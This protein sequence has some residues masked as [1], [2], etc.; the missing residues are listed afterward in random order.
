MLID[1][2]KARATMDIN[3]ELSQDSPT[4]IPEQE[5]QQE[6]S[7]ATA[8]SRDSDE[9]QRQTMDIRID[10]SKG[11]DSPGSPLNLPTDVVGDSL[12]TASEMTIIKAEDTVNDALISNRMPCHKVE[13]F[14]HKIKQEEESCGFSPSTT[15]SL[16]D[17]HVSSVGGCESGLLPVSQHVGEMVLYTKHTDDAVV[18]EEEEYPGY[19]LTRKRKFPDDES[20]KPFNDEFWQ[21]YTH[22][23][24]LQNQASACSTT[25]YE[26]TSQPPFKFQIIG[27][28][29]Q[30]SYTSGFPMPEAISRV[31]SI[32]NLS[33]I[34]NQNQS[35][36]RGNDPENESSFLKILKGFNPLKVR[37]REAGK[38]KAPALKSVTKAKLLQEILRSCPKTS[39]AKRNKS[40]LEA[41]KAAV[42]V[43]GKKIKPKD[44]KWLMNNMNSALLN[45]QAIGLAWMYH[46]ERSDDPSKGGMLCDSMARFPTFMV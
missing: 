29:G 38:D 9:A 20:E 1:L 45:H 25:A 19:A 26:H 28:S 12:V 27:R 42:N 22:Q 8:D 43:F 32:R 35:G 4:P 3:T 13:S 39:D 10:N 7:I 34:L 16:V 2:G 40:D 6:R 36:D 21:N 41:L 46:R 37:D 44:G 15:F 31:S 24:G 5:D 30:S 14:D 18:K 11:D 17:A 33:H 23:N